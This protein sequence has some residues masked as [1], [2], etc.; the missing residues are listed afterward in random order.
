MTA[1]WNDEG[2][3]REPELLEAE[4]YLAFGHDCVMDPSYSMGTHDM[5][6]VANM[7]LHVAKMISVKGMRQAFDAVTV[8]RAKV[9]EL[10]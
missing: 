10:R 4:I 2:V 8:N 3:T 7:R 5:L 1:I 6:K 9:M